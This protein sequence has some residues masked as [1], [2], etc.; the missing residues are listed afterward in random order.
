LI[1]EELEYVFGGFADV[2]GAD[3]AEMGQSSRFFAEEFAEELGDLVFSVEVV[4]LDSKDA[5]L[6]SQGEVLKE[7][8]VLRFGQGGLKVSFE[9]LIE[10]RAGEIVYWQY[11]QT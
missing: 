5:I 8:D 1:D 4:E 9:I 7:Y 2:V 11:R 6:G 3:V 10:G